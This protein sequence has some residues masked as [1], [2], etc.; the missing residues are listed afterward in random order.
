MRNDHFSSMSLRT[1]IFKYIIAHKSMSLRTK[2]I[3]YRFFAKLIIFISVSALSCIFDQIPSTKIAF[4]ID[5]KLGF[6]IFL[7]KKREEGNSGILLLFKTIFKIL[8]IRMAKL[9]KKTNSQDDL[10]FKYLST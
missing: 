1:K 7:L 2:W 8:V 5:N 6:L 9:G 10:L 4:P 3:K